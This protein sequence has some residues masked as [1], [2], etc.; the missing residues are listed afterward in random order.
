MLIELANRQLALARSEGSAMR[1]FGFNID[2]SMAAPWIVAI[3]L[4]ALGTLVVRR[5]W[6]RVGDAWGIVNAR[7]QYRGAT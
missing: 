3:L 4:F 5:L 2:A 6:P 7:L 1:L